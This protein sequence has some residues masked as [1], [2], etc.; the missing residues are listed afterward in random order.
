VATVRA[1]TLIAKVVTK[2][3]KVI[4]DTK[5]VPTTITKRPAG[6]ISSAEVAT[7][8]I[9]A[10]SSNIIIPLEHQADTNN[11]SSIRSKDPKLV[12]IRTKDTKVRIRTI[13]LSSVIHSQI[14]LES[15]RDMKL[16]KSS[17]SPLH[18]ILKDQHLIQRLQVRPV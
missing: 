2:D 13:T 12:I 17:A 11:S 10:R 1:A 14:S 8:I 5:M 4:K 9:R 16:R 18:Q 3:T 7:H 15:P 6:K